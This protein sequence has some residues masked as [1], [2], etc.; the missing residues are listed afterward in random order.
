MPSRLHDEVR[1]VRLEG[2]VHHPELTTVG[3]LGE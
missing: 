1:V 3:D 2:V